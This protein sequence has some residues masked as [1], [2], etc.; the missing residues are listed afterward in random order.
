MGIVGNLTHRY[1]GYIRKK[2]K[3]S[4]NQI[5]RPRFSSRIALETRDSDKSHGSR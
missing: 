4:K 3:A 1:T 5:K 2:F